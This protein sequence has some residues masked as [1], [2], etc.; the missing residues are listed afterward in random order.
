LESSFE[1]EFNGYIFCGHYPHFFGQMIVKCE[2]RNA[3]IPYKLGRREGSQSLEQF[4][5]FNHI[6][7]CVC[8]PMESLV[9]VPKRD[10]R[11]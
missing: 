5:R 9:R 7:F 1:Y 10:D 8:I 4:D 6:Y 11:K 3:W 2:P